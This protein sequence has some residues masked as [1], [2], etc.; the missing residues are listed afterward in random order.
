MPSNPPVPELRPVVL[1]MRFDALTVPQA[2][3]RF[4]ELATAP[5]GPRGCCVAATVNVAVSPISP[6]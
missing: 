1:G 3:D 4:F 2:M 6:G 5:R